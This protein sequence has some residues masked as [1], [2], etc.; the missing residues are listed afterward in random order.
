MWP[1]CSVCELI[2]QRQGRVDAAHTEAA[3]NLPTEYRKTGHLMCEDNYCFRTCYVGADGGDDD[4]RHA[5]PTFVR[6]NTA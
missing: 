2:I 4:P 3:D 1:S 6:E 5:L